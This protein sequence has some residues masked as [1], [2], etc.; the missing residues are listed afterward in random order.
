MAEHTEADWLAAHVFYHDRLDPLLVE[1]VAPL[2]AELRERDLASEW[3]FLRYWDGGPHLRFRVLPRDASARAEVGELVR[4]RFERYLAERPAADRVEPT[5][6]Q[7]SAAR[8]AGWEGLE[9]YA[10]LRPNNSV[11]FRPYVRERHRFGTGAAMAAVERHFAESSRLAL[12]LL[13]GGLDDDQ[14]F[15]AAYSLLVL[16]WLGFRDDP[17]WRSAWAEMDTR[18]PIGGE[19]D[20]AELERRWQRQRSTLTALTG[21]LRAVAGRQGR[22][23]LAEWTGSV[24]RLKRV[25]TAEAA[26]G[27]FTPPARA[28]EGAGPLPPGTPASV[29]PVI[30]ICAH[31]FCNRIGLSLADE[32]YVRVLAMRAVRDTEGEE[33]ER[34]A[35][36]GDPRPLP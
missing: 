33:G 12:R 20:Q 24:D 34:H 21:R 14:R 35:V 19:L 22:G 4:G 25:L 26:A 2:V 23:D 8:I 32:S 3:F 27:R 16:A 1:A 18:I 5:E 31:L 9:A 10:E 30:D 11:E 7:R 28:W 29:L 36:A 13:A 15:T 17:A 6:Y